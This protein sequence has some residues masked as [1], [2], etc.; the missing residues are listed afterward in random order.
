MELLKSL[1][2]LGFEKR[3][4]LL[5]LGVFLLMLGMMAI[6]A[7]IYAAVIAIMVYVSMRVFVGRR[8]RQIQREVGKGLCATCGTKIEES[9][10]PRCDKD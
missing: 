3:E 1:I 4:I 9:K 10:C 2:E 5:I 8:M 6:L 7:P